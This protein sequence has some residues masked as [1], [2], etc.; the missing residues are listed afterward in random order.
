MTVGTSLEDAAG[1]PPTVSEPLAAGN[2]QTGR[3]TNADLLEI[4]VPIRLSSPNATRGHHWSRRHAET[5]TWEL[6]I[7]AYA[8]AGHGSWSLVASA[9]LTQ[10]RRGRRRVKL[11][12]IRECR[13]VTVTRLVPSSRNFIRDEE[14]LR[15]ST[16][17][18]NDALKRLGFLYDDSRRWL[19]QPLPR[20]E[21]APDGR[22]V[23]VIQ[24]ERVTDVER[25][26]E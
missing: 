22:D 10:D 1:K 18:V 6:L 26:G 17:P 20:E 9:T 4:R 2:F 11:Q 23:T 3:V 15:F 7:P 21:V 24:I 19:E 14:N 25:T 13:R 16:K 12:R 5:N 8:P